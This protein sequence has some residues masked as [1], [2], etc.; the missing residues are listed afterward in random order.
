MT[1]ARLSAAL[2]T[3]HWG[4]TALAEELDVNERTVRRW[5]SGQNEAP[6]AVVR[7]LERLAAFHEAHPPP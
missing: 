1:T 3:L 6:A 4:P 5:L 2:H 7:W